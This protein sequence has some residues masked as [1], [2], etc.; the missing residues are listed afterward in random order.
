[1]MGERP[2]NQGGNSTAHDGD[3]V[4]IVFLF[5]CDK[6]TDRTLYRE[7]Y[8]LDVDQVLHYCKHL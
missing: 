3:A 2:V 8:G 4:G 1:M 5:E 7:L 6:R